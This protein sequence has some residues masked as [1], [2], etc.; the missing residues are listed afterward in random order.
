[1]ASGYPEARC[2]G[3]AEELFADP[4][5]EGVVISTPASTHFALARRALEAG[6]HV[7]VEKPITANSW[8]ARELVRVAKGGNTVLMVGHVFE[9]NATVRT[10]K[11]LINSGELGEIYYLHFERTNLGPIRTDVNA[12]WDLAT[13]DVSIMCYL[14]DQA[15]L[16]VTSRGQAFLNAGIEDAIFSSF[17]FPGGV[18][19]HVHASWLHP[20]K[21]RQIT[22]VGSR[23]MA[24]WDDLDLRYP[25]QIYDKHIDEPQEIPDTYIAYKTQVV[26]GGVFSPSVQLNQPLQA[27]CAHFI[28]CVEHHL[29]PHSGGLSGLRVVLSAE[30]ALASMRNGSAITPVES[31]PT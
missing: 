7:L 23:R 10:L 4:E 18:L 27:E 2:T 8:E 17:T 5:L 31:M 14:L 20:R 22:V 25:I 24:L 29:Q 13:H 11:E 21:V 19:A 16:E 12:L 26:D 1:V 15:P 3:E 9:Y 6:K 28:D 30:A